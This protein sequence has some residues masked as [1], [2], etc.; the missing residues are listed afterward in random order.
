MTGQAEAESIRQ[1]ALA[2]SRGEV[3]CVPTE[4]SYGLAADLRSAAGLAKITALK[5]GRPADSPFPLIAG[6]IE[7]ARALARVWPEA[8]ERL[9]ARHWPGPLTLVVPARPG[10]P[11]EVV[12]P[13]GGVGVRVSSHPIAAALASALGA[14]TA[15]SANRSGQPPA[16]TAA[17]ARAGFGGELSLYLDGGVCAGVPS[18]VVEVDEDGR[19][20]LLRPGPIDLDT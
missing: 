11:A 7:E 5:G 17:Q 6:A 18:T 10:L 19:L 12:G 15:T 1:A 2:L 3:V 16:T 4:S 20:R 14:I 13:G 9:A 8:A